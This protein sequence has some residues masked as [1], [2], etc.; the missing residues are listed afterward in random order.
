MNAKEKEQVI[1]AIEALGR[2]VSVAQVAKKTG[3]NGNMVFSA[4]REIAAATGSNLQVVKDGEICFIFPF[5]F[6]DLYQS[7]DRTIWLDEAMRAA[8]DLCFFVG[9]IVFAITLLLM[10]YLFHPDNSAI[11]PYYLILIFGGIY[12]ELNTADNQRELFLGVGQKKALKKSLG[13]GNLSKLFSFKYRER[14]QDLKSSLLALL[15]EEAPPDNRGIS[16][17]NVCFSFVFGDGNPNIQFD[18]LKWQ[19]VAEVIRQHNGAVITDQLAPYLCCAPED[20]DAML[21]VLQRFNGIPRAT[22][23]GNLVYLFPELMKAE[24]EKF[25]V[26]SYLTERTWRFS[27]LPFPQILPVWIVSSLFFLLAY[28]QFLHP[29]SLSWLWTDLFPAGRN[30]WGL[31][32]PF[33]FFFCV[34]PALRFIY[35]TLTNGEIEERNK[36]RKYFA[37][38][39]H[40]P[41]DQLFQKLLERNEFQ[42]EEMLIQSRPEDVYYTTQKSLNEQNIND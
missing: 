6:I 38:T 41:D 11:L 36:L 29:D 17:F 22:E 40:K 10:I 15:K 31:I 1:L 35:I 13:F 5:N 18:E 23:N 25:R 14:S 32:L 8:F 26:P 39:V 16:F 20:D 37:E 2:S 12:F 42:L 7:K 21:P 4:L 3:L 27:D 9:R 30:L 28:N 24:K 34:V 19:V 33:S